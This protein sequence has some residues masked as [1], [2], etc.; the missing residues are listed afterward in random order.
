[1]S[2]ESTDADVILPGAE[3]RRMIN[4][5]EQLRFV[6]DDLNRQVSSSLD[7]RDAAL[8]ENARLREAVDTYRAESLVMR[9]AL[10]EI[11]N[12]AEHDGNSALLLDTVRE[13][14]DAVVSWLRARALVEPQR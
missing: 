12:A 7:Q 6:T 9:Q 13:Q 4:E 3:F 2:D 10:N 14:S 1:M 8:A 11:L 5:L